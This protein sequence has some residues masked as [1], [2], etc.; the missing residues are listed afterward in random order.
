MRATLAGVAIGADAPVRVMAVLNVS[1]ESFYAGSVHASD[2]ALQTAARQAVDEGAD[3]IDIGAR[4]TAP[5]LRTAV[6]APDEM[7]RMVRAVEV[8]RTAVGVPIS[9]DTTHAG[10]AAAALA[11]GARIVNDVS[12]L[13]G[14]PAMADVAAQADGVILVAA[15]DGGP[16]G[17]PLA[18]VRRVLAD[19]RRR[20]AAAGIAPDEIVLDPG[21]GFFHGP[22]ESAVAFNCAVLHALGA[23]ADLGSPLL[24]GVSRKA[25][26]GRLTGRCDP[27]ARLFG[28]VAAAALAVYN[29]AAI[30]RAHDV[31]ATRD[32]VRIAEAIRRG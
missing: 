9:A 15:P 27:G 25:F 1:P 29:G 5:Y 17:P 30:I 10:V 7:R 32:A 3:F 2:A 21:I 16:S 23:L 31:A 18:A 24:V 8:V 13:R 6:P 28:S 11:S 14:D 20:A 4:S 19:S 26:I 22:G 12:G